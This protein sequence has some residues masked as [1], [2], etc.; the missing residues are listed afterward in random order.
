[1]RGGQLFTSHLSG[2]RVRPVPSAATLSH[3][4][5]LNVRSSERRHSSSSTA[6]ILVHVRTKLYSN[7]SITMSS[8]WLSTMAAVAPAP[9]GMRDQ[10]PGGPFAGGTP[11]SASSSG[12]EAAVAVIVSDRR[13]GFKR[14]TRPLVK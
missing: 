1:M 5:T 8:S 3:S 7:H 4:K 14:G 9:A 11:S 13:S 12:V 6:S 10:R 2:Y